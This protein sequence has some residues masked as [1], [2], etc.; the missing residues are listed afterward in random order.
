M[1]ELMKLLRGRKI[2]FQLIDGE[3]KLLE[4]KLYP[5]STDK[6]P[7]LCESELELE[8]DEGYTSGNR[9]IVKVLNGGWFKAKAIGIPTGSSKPIY[10]NGI[11]Y[12][13]YLNRAFIG[14]G[15]LI[16]G[17]L[18][19]DEAEREFEIMVKVRDKELPSPKPI[20]IGLYGRVKVLDFP[21]R[22]EMFTYLQG[23]ARKALIK[24]FERKGR[25]I[26]AA[27]LFCLQ[28]GDVRVDEILYGL[29]FPKINEILDVR[30]IK[31]YLKWLGSS[32]AYNLRRYHD[33]DMLHGTVIVG[34]G[35][36]TNSHLGNHI[37][38]FEET[39][40]T[41]FHMA[42]EIE[43]R[44]DENLKI[45]EYY[46]LWYIMNPL[47]GGEKFVYARR[48]RISLIQFPDLSLTNIP[49]DR[50]TAWDATLRMHA[51]EYIPTSLLEEFTDALITGF[52]YGYNRRK[53]L[54]IEG[55]LKREMLV[56]LA[57]LKNGLWRLYKLPEGMQRGM[58]ILKV[59][60]DKRKIEDE[61][62]KMVVDEVKRKFEEI[63]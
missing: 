4:R 27:S 33:E 14:S 13:Y 31:A 2:K 51:G 54:E 1:D 60:M 53:I 57:V 26:S 36:M 30:E 18:T 21:N 7:I 11:I 42:R 38:N 58:E 19:L 47:P 61:K 62:V 28:N 45:E 56:K 10:R 49:I 17:F 39:S 3:L 46:A 34:N 22:F 37:V 6:L 12:T 25:E 55:R 50:L 15:K 32:C 63:F 44:M 43:S 9:S 8:G 23:R 59:I 20:G 24:E 40:I 5:Y 16:W 52:E 29:L 35:I 48:R 41:D